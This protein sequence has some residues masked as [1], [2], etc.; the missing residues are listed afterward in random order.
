MLDK[1]SAAL[2]KLINPIGVREISP[3]KPHAGSSGT[4]DQKSREPQEFKR[5]VIEE[6]Q[7]PVRT[8]PEPLPKRAKTERPEG[9]Q[10]GLTSSFISLLSR[11][12]ERRSKA[13][14]RSRPYGR[15]GAANS[16]P[17]STLK[18]GMILD[19]EG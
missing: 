7:E 18:K 6:N 3:I 14:T 9:V 1:I 12:N 2:S 19:D 11:L 13:R 4:S 8:A 15:E 16:K 17:I 10:P 5:A